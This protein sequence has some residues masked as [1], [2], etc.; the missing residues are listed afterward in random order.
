MR[1][2]YNKLV[3]DGIPEIIEQSGKQFAVEIML[4]GEYAQALLAKLVEEATE[5]WEAEPESLIAELAD[6]YEVIAAILVV[7]GI[8]EESVRREQLRKRSERVSFARRI[9]LIWVE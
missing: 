2:E 7:K 8:S 5:A 6:L 4:E 1:Q 9:R 3:R